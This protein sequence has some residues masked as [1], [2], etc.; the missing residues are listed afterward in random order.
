MRLTFT[1]QLSPKERLR[2]SV[3]LYVESFHCSE[4]Q[5]IIFSDV[6][7]LL[8]ADWIIASGLNFH[9][10]DG[11][12]KLIGCFIRSQQRRNNQ[13]GRISH[14]IF[15]ANNF[16]VSPLCSGRSP[17]DMFAVLAHLFYF[18]VALFTSKLAKYTVSL[19]TCR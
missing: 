17:A 12:C 5:P 1:S 11:S 2:A 15:T 19:I 16:S 4:S 7:K 14:S 9:L 8:R 18:A 3:V 10:V 6:I 13:R